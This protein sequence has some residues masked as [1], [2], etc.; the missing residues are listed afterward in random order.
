MEYHDWLK[1]L[2]V[3]DE[4]IYH[5]WGLGSHYALA[6]V[7]RITP[8]GFIRVNGTLFKPDTGYAINCGACIRDPN[9]DKAM[10]ALKEYNKAVFVSKTMRRIRNTNMSNVTYE[11]AVEIVKIMGWE[12]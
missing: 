7:E 12:V 8:T 11:Q 6:K 5:A 4:V 3:G 1:R 10:E 9:E 2:K